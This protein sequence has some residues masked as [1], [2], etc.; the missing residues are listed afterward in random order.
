MALQFRSAVGSGQRMDGWGEKEEE[1]A[2]ETLT[3]MCN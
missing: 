2:V 3:P 1:E